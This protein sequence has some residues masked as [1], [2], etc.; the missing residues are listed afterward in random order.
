MGWKVEINDCDWM[1]VHAADS[2]EAERIGVDEYLRITGFTREILRDEFDNHEIIVTPEPKLDGGELTL[3][4]LVAL[5]LCIE[6]SVDD[7]TDGELDKSE[8]A[9]LLSTEY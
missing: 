8:A 6:S 5:G 4:R 9:I 2:T 1:M 7:V 3:R